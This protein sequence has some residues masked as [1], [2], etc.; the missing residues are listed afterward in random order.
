MR[1]ATSKAMLLKISLSTHEA[2]SNWKFTGVTE[3][4]ERYGSDQVGLGQIC[5]SGSFFLHMMACHRKAAAVSGLT[6]RHDRI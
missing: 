2:A 5:G 6:S 3:Q 4:V 1:E